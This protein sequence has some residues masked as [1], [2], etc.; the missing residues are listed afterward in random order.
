[1][2]AWNLIHLS[3][4]FTSLIL[5]MSP[6]Y[7][8][9]GWLKWCTHSSNFEQ[10]CRPKMRAIQPIEDEFWRSQRWRCAP[11]CAK[12][13]AE[14]NLKSNGWIGRNRL[15]NVWAKLEKKKMSLERKMNVVMTR[16][17]RGGESRRVIWLWYH[18]GNEGARELGQCRLKAMEQCRVICIHHQ[19]SYI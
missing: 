2:V 18:V 8:P 10:L 1:M 16:G 14:R 3:S 12:P 7:N 6:N 13:V 17:K 19:P 5:K 15:C 4:K 11:Y 9:E